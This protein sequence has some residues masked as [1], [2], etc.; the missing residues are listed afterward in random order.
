MSDIQIAL[1]IM[2]KGMAGIFAVTLVFYC[3]YGCW[4]GLEREIAQ[5]IQSNEM[6]QAVAKRSECGKIKLCDCAGGS[7]ESHLCCRFAVCFYTGKLLQG[8]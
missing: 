8:L 3:L 2:V 1:I 5:K 7:V 6:N 4:E